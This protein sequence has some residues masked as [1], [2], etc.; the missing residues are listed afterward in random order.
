MHVSAWNHVSLSVRD[1]AASLDWYTTVLGLELAFDEPAADDRRAV[2]LRFRE[3][4][5][6]LGLT[7]HGDG[8]APF[9][10][11][12]TGLDH[13]AFRV[14]TADEMDEWAAHLDAHGVV[15]SGPIDIPPGR[16]LNFKDPDGI[17]L[18]LMWLREA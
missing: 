13:A 11:A 17:A 9:D 16:I 5:P 12:V 7:Q 14:A 18:A 2:V 8:G 10:P 4:G 3:S 15:H 6:A 1:L